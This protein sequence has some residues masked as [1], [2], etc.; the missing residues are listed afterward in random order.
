VLIECP[1]C[2]ATAKIADDKAGAKVRCGG[3]QKVYV[4]SEV[5][6]DPEESRSALIKVLAIAGGVLVLGV[7]ILIATHKSPA[8]PP[9]PVVQ[10]APPPKPEKPVDSIG[11]DSAP[12]HAVRDLYEAVHAHDVPKTRELLLGAKIAQARKPTDADALAKWKSYESMTPLEREVYLGTV[13]DELAADTGDLALGPWK[14][15]DGSVAQTDGNVATVRV[16]V[17]AREAQAGLESRTMDF[18]A[19]RD[20]EHWKIASWKRYFTEAE[21]RAAEANKTSG[22]TK[23][24]F[25]DGTVLYQAEPQRVEH[26]P[27]TSPEL[28][29]KI[30]ET[31]ARMID[32]KLDPKENNRALAELIAFGK[33]AIPVLLT[34]MYE[35]KIVDDDSAA[36]VNL[37]NQALE[38]I[39]GQVK[40][41]SG[42]GMTE[43]RRTAS[44]KA[45]FGWWKR[46]GDKFQSRPPEEDAL[47][48]LEK[49]SAKKNG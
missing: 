9:A 12:V 40:G 30:D 38:G 4:A 31:Y 26:L 21:L 43:E 13:A 15:Y 25:A 44:I 24:S 5:G 35:T 33:P 11:W 6:D 2:H 27:D 22:I 16:K 18:D 20:G 32:F 41:F 7:I 3:C 14:P 23:V 29:A 42:F 28:R 17:S 45:W 48:A 10:A 49:K 36:K 47:E 39:T 19:M 37:V 46:V 34:G 8:P 1:H